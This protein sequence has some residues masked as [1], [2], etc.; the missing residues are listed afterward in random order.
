MIKTC[1]AVLLAACLLWPMSGLT[2]DEFTIRD[3]RVEG[4]QRISAGTVFNYLPV[5]VGSNISPSDY[6]EL[7]RALFDTGFFADVSLARDN[8]VLVIRV[9]ERPAI[10]EISISGNKDIATDDLKNSLKNIGLAEGQVFNRSLLQQIE[11]ELLRQYLGRGKYGVDIQTSTSTLPRNRVA[12]QLQIS[13][14]VAARIRQIN[15]VGNEAFDDEEL[16]DQFSLSTT[17]WLS[18]IS[19]DDQ[20]SRQQ[21]TADIESLRS[22]YFDRGYVR[23]NVDSTQVSISPDKKDIYITINITEGQSYTVREIQLTG[24]MVVPQSEL[25]TLLTLKSGDIFSRSVLNQDSQRIAGRLADDGY[26]F[27]TVDTVPRIDQA[28]Q[29]VDLTFVVEPGE[30]VYVRRINFKGNLKT[31]DEVLRREMRQIEG[32]W[33]S[34]KDVDRSRV[35]LQRLEYMAN[36][37]LETNP[38]VGTPDQVD[39]DFNLT[40]RASG[41]LVFGI[42]FGQESG[43]LLNASVSQKNFFGTGNEVGFA[44]NNSDSDTVYRISFNDPYYTIDGVSRG[45][46]L[47]YEETDTSENNTADYIIDGL[48]GEVHYGFPVSE[49]DT[50][51]AGLGYDGLRVRETNSSPAEIVSFLDE[52]GERYDNFVLRL[53]YARDKR[54]RAIFPDKGS[55]NRLA[56]EVALPGSDTEYYKVD[57]RHQSFYPFNDALILSA[58]A[59]VGYADGYGSSDELP[60]FENYF[61]GGLRTVRGFKANTLGPRYAS[62]DEP[63]GGAFRVTGGAEAIVPANFFSDG[64]NVRLSAFMDIGNVF[65]KVSDFDSG[66]LRYSVGLA[67]QWLSPIGPLVLSYAEPLNDE[68]DDEKESFQFSFGVPF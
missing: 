50:L 10:G 48:K 16:L 18:F 15:I 26:A 37:E 44:F 41:S 49:F 64:D 34:K 13:E 55:L 45:F 17:G 31:Q 8:D 62:N 56:A 39:L 43:L 20:Y 32:G 38:V 30:R 36:V 42:G 40:E 5:G 6:P 1:V 24:D 25:E 46:S 29:Q 23:F 58:R 63:A 27:A 12:V 59:N 65:A 9:L 60:F 66:D 61:A 22:Y 14:G 3:I 19:K 57:L 53:S 21:L 52:N 35:R 28:E 67:V 51:R 68:G 11:Q 54:N 2:Q 7:I 47:S 33:F 4:L